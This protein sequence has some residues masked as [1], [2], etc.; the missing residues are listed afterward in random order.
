M[1]RT[2]RRRHLWVWIGLALVLPIGVI[3]GL[4]TRQSDP[5]ETRFIELVGGADAETTE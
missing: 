4:V 3:L 5:V 1:K 2:H